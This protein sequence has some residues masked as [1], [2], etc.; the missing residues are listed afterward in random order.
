MHA[1]VCV[2]MFLTMTAGK[3]C[4]RKVYWRMF[5]TDLKDR[6][7]ASQI[8]VYINFFTLNVRVLDVVA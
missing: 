6:I 5:E 7:V 8:Y 3:V 4:L 2:C 1:C